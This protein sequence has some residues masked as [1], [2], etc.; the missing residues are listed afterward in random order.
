M[1][2]FKV[3]KL[4][5][6]V[7]N[8]EK[9][10]GGEITREH[11]PR[12][13]PIGTFL[14]KTKLNELPQL[15]N[16]LKGDMSVIGHRPLVPSQFGMYAIDVQKEMATIKPGLSGIGSIVFRDEEHLMSFSE[17]GYDD[18][19]EKIITPYKGQLEVW[20]TKNN[21]L[22]NYFKIILLTFVVI[23]KPDA[24]ILKTSFTGLPEPGQEMKDLM[25]K[26]SEAE[27]I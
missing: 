27:S 7:K 24:K 12:V 26:A 5:T 1:K 17:L 20:Y 16:V 13:L 18:C 19:F 25:N 4:T 11:D 23:F 15:V 2:L 9:M 8:S 22:Y 21:S 14:R 6:M 3:F 10:E